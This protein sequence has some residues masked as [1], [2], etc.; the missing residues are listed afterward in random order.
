VD[1]A[2]EVK[3]AAILT[4]NYNYITPD[5]RE[6]FH[7]EFDSFDAL[8]KW[9]KEDSII[10]IN[11]SMLNKDNNEKKL[12]LTKLAFPAVRVIVIAEDEKHGNELFIYTTQQH[13]DKVIDIQIINKFK[14]DNNKESL[15][16]VIEQFNL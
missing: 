3:M 11:N 2:L 15:L 1:L 7:K 5:N 16:K 9:L 4:L 8:T 13:L 14:F 12:V 6:W 10:I